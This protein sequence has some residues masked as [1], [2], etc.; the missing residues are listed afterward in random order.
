MSALTTRTGR[1]DDAVVAARLHAAEVSDGFLSSLGPGFLTVLYRRVPRSPGCWLLLAELEG[2]PIGFLAGTVDTSALYRRVLAH[3]GPAA[4]R[5]A[6]LGLLRRLP[7]AVETLRYPQRTAAGAAP[8]PAAELLA[9]A[10]DPA[11]RG[12]GAGRALVEA[13]QIRLTTS[14]TDAARVTVGSGNAAALALYRSC[15]FID[16][17]RIEVHRGAPSE[18]LVWRPPGS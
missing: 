8:L 10:V 14:Q 5:A 2:R 17:A 11:A 15:G 4:L 16:H 13:F 1:P 6:G 3:D 7:R 18:V 12:Q 9:M